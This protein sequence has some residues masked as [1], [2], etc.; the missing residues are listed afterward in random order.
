[1]AFIKINKTLLAKQLI[2]TCPI[3]VMLMEAILRTWRTSTAWASID[4]DRPD[5]DI[6]VIYA[7]NDSLVSAKFSL[8]DDFKQQTPTVL[9][10]L[11]ESQDCKRFSII[12]SR[13]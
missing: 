11:D 12:V 2:K 7:R 10:F 13:M 4:D 5:D 1:M 6:F 3:L 8:T 9:F